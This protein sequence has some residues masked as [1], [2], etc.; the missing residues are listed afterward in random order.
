MKVFGIGLQKTGTSTLGIC[1]KKLGYSLISYNHEAIVSYKNGKLHEL[2]AITEK[3]D[4]F[5]DEPWAHA[6]A[7]L[8]SWYPEAKFILTVRKDSETWFRTMCSHCQRIQHNPHRSFFF[9]HEKPFE[10]K[11]EYIEVYE[12]HNQEVINLF[13]D[14]KNQFLIVCW[15]KGDGWKQICEFLNKPIPDIPFPHANKKPF[16]MYLFLKKLFLSLK[17]LV[18]RE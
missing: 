5:E 16:F 1:L 4:S 7:S 18:K 8:L 13:K 10:H 14:R 15:E 9:G 2:R 17:K 3:Y 6:F 12:S 11:K